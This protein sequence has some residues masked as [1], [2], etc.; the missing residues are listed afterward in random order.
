MHQP[1]MPSWFG[2]D[3]SELINSVVSCWTEEVT[4][5]LAWKKREHTDRAVAASH[6]DVPLRCPSARVSDGSTSL[7]TCEGPMGS[8]STT[9]LAFSRRPKRL[10]SRSACQGNLKPE[11]LLTMSHIGSS[12]R[13]GIRFTS[14][15]LLV[16]LFVDVFA[17][18]MDLSQ[19]FFRFCFSANRILHSTCS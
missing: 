12:S 17:V 5:E 14:L 2:P 3:W 19:V 16:V 11:Q 9:T 10:L 13:T 8:A 18:D 1:S 7:A 15:N 4:C 6:R